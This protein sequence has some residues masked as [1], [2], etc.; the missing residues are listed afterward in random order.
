MF[1]EERLAKIIELLNIKGKVVVK[2]LSRE[3][4]VTE[5]CVRKDL[6]ILE[7]D[8]LIKR[9]YGGA[10][11]SR[12]TAPLD[13]VS[14]RI[15]NNSEIKKKIAQKAYELIEDRE[16]IF[17][18]ISTTN[19]FLA[20]QICNGN[21]QITVVT[22]MLDVVTALSKCSSVKIICIGGVFNKELDGFIG[23]SA[24]ESIAKYKV[25]KSF[26][27]SCG[28]D[29]FDSSV[30]TFDVDDGCT[31]KAII[32]AGKKI[33]LVMGKDKFYFDGTYKFAQLYDIDAIIVDEIPEDKICIA[34]DE[35]KVDL[36]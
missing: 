16:T 28:V 4:E 30:T 36:I 27:G 24:I 19:I 10:V 33:Y 1:A 31:K 29:I 21:K 5:D 11:L 6:K 26:I 25:D 12:K 2:E 9:T 32:N 7:Q 8:G 15:Y 34:L 14:N 23:A 20:E 18:D 22:N 13:D 17:L 35:M 3:F